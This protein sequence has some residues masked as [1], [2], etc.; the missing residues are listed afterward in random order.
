MDA[1]IQMRVK[2]KGPPKAV[3][4][5][6]LPAIQDL[7]PREQGYMMGYSEGFTQAQVDC[8]ARLQQ[9]IKTSRAQWDAVT[10]MLNQFPHAMAQKFREQLVELAFSAVRKILAATS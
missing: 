10:K 4:S 3:Q 5:R 1:A 2:L 6:S 8:E 9:Q 7:D